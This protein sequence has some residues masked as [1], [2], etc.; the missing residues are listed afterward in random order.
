MS[1]RTHFWLRLAALAVILAAA[2]LPRS[3]DSRPSAASAQATAAS[4]VL[5]ADVAR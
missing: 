3:S 4:H 5:H 1:N 2:W